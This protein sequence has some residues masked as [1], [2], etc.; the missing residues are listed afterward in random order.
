MKAKTKAKYE[1]NRS[2][3]FKK[4]EQIDE[5]LSELRDEVADQNITTNDLIDRLDEIGGELE[6]LA[7]EVEELK[8]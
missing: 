1:Y 3:L 8:D 7:N 4:I 6:V 2:E 5:S